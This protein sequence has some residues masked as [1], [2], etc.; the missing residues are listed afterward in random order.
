MLFL[1][2]IKAYKLCWKTHLIFFMVFFVKQ[3]LNHGPV[4]SLLYFKD[5]LLYGIGPKLNVLDLQTNKTTL[6]LLVFQNSKIHG[7]FIQNNILYVY[8]GRELVLVDINNW[9]I[10]LHTCL[11]DW[12]LDVKVL[13]N[14]TVAI[15]FMNNFLEVWDLFQGILL[16]KYSSEVHCILY[17]GKIYGN[18]ESNLKIASGTVFNQVLLWRLDGDRNDKDEIKVLNTCDGHEGVI[19]GIQ[20]ND[21]ASLLCSVS[22]DRSIRVWSGLWKHNQIN[23]ESILFGH[24]ARIWKGGFLDKDTL[25]SVSEDCTCRLWDYKEQECVK[26]YHGHYGKHVWSYALDTENGRIFTGGGDSSIKQ[27][28]C[29][30]ND[31][32]HSVSLKDNPRIKSFAFSDMDTLY[33]FGDYGCV[34]E[35]TGEGFSNQKCIYQHDLIK[36]YALI[37]ASSDKLY[38]G[39]MFG[40]LHIV[41]IRDFRSFLLENILDSKITD[42]FIENEYIFVC[43]KNR[44]INILKNFHV[45][46]RITLDT[47]DFVLSVCM[48]ENRI[49]LGSRDGKI[50]VYDG[51][52]NYLFEEVVRPNKGVTDIQIRNGFILVSDRGGYI[53]TFRLLESNLEL[54]STEKVSKGWIEKLVNVKGDTLA[55]CFFNKA[56]STRNTN[57]KVQLMNVPCGGQHRRWQFLKNEKHQRFAFHRLNDIHYFDQDVETI[58]K[59]SVEIKQAI[60]GLEIR[61][62]DCKRIEKDI[63]IATGGEDRKI[64]IWKFDGH[65]LDLIL[66]VARHKSV[67]RSLK[68]I[69]EY[70]VSCGGEC[71]LL[72]W[73]LN[74]DECILQASLPTI[75]DLDVRIMDFCIFE[76]S[77]YLN[78]VNVY[79]N[80]LLVVWKYEDGLFTVRNSS[81]LDRCPLHLKKINEAEFITSGTDGKIIFWDIREIELKPKKEV[82][83]HQSGIHAVDYIYVEDKHFVVSAG[84]DCDISLYDSE[85]VTKKRCAHFSPIQSVMFYKDYIISCSVDQKIKLWSKD[86]ELLFE[87][88]STVSDI[89]ASIVVE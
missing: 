73:K 58:A 80:G 13:N 47:D 38:I 52:C 76:Y 67:I 84:D 21:D 85:K 70:L 16:R 37:E 33:I 77:N 49:L 86:F 42:I 11:K 56:F 60:H 43:S 89:S 32:V 63:I 5:K 59:G 55:C 2:L 36:G 46:G 53:S 28:D 71:E 75:T 68:F 44:Q 18:E 72:L 57:L 74:S 3:V 7:M 64:K 82:L 26:I 62:V 69:G 35:C 6:S 4:T 83:V 25:I 41:D 54:V 1:V 61:T 17:S 10:L 9:N 48:L 15:I 45:L 14:Q 78:V 65:S 88:R 87:C 79:S 31:S 8:G 34:Y 20:F 19:F 22:D 30:L 81:N 23:C 66:Q 39:D 12:I 27:W 24:N 29:K 51:N 50:F 40:N